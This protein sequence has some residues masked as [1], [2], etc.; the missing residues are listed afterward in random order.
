MIFVGFLH[1]WAFPDY[2]YRQ[3]WAQNV[4]HGN[5]EFSRTTHFFFSALLFRFH[6]FS[7]CAQ[8]CQYS[9]TSFCT[10]GLLRVVGRYS[11]KTLFHCRIP[12]FRIWTPCITPREMGVHM[13]FLVFRGLYFDMHHTISL[14][15]V[16]F[17]FHLPIHTA[18]RW[19]QLNVV[20]NSCGIC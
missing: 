15:V 9:H 12:F 14:Q 17:G 20:S 1:Y 11:N 2:L 3:I 6:A 5:I 16:R 18:D 13:S 19:Q 7:E 4:S 10:T 8:E